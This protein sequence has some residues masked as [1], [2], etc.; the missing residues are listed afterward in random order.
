VTLM[1][2]KSESQSTLSFSKALSAGKLRH[3]S[4][5]PLSSIPTINSSKQARL[6]VD[7]IVSFKLSQKPVA[8]EIGFNVCVDPKAKTIIKRTTA[9]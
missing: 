6:L 3:G 4:I 7:D 1:G 2:L 9:L 8:V 5:P